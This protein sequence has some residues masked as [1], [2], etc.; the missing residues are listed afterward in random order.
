MA[1]LS[2]NN[3]N[4]L[5]FKSVKNSVENYFTTNN[6]KKTGNWK[7][8]LKVIILFPLVIA[9]YL[10][11][12]FGT[13]SI[14]SG[15]LLSIFFGIILSA[16]AFNVMHDACHGSFSSRKWV[17]ETMGL[18]M[19]ALGSAAYFW[20]IKHNILHHTYTNVDG[21]DDDIAKSPLL[22][23]CPSQRWVPAHRFQFLYIF[24]LYPFTTF[25]WM[26]VFDY[27]KYFAK[28]VH[29][30]EINKIPF[31]EHVIFWLTKVLYFVFYVI[32]PI[33]FLGWQAWLTGFAIMHFTF[34]VI[35]SIVFM[36]AHVV[37]KTSFETAGDEP[38]VLESQW[39]KH[40]V[41]TT[42]NF[43]AKN[44]MICWFVGGLNFQIEH[45]LF[46]RIS[47]IHYSK[48]SQIVKSQC[49]IFNIPYHY[50]PTM[51]NAV[52]SHVRLMKQL[53]KKN[54]PASQ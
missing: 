22:R 44:K 29:T 26:M 32:I 12:L 21:I 41:L 51:F 31:K 35:L 9:V 37:E 8:Y 47:H 19:N 17:N 34:G 28:R 49:D 3:Q 46:P 10:F 36:L 2:F 54:F 23:M 14:I 42:A 5:F 7:L 38:R 39:A 53:G 25:A 4:D 20:K 27:V 24:L 48:I 45:H 11:L 52:S 30:T 40:Q 1:K 43:A 33:I 13:Y 18:T 50:Y 15:I 16:I 6:L